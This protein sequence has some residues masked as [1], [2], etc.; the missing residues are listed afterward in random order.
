MPKLTIGMATY[1]DFDGV[2]FTLQ[3]LR[4]YHN[5]DDIEL[6]VVDNEGNGRLKKWIECWGKGVVRYERYTEKVGTSPSRHMVFR[7]ASGDYVICVDSHVL[8]APNSLDRLWEGD[9]LIHGVM[10]Y[11]NN[12]SCVTCM[13]DEWRSNMWGIWDE[14]KK[15]ED[16]PEEPFEIWGHGLG[17]FGCRKEVWLGFNPD[18]RGFGGEEGY[19]HEKFRKHGRKVLCLPWMRWMH[20]F[21]HKVSYPLNMNDRIRNYLYEFDEIGL[22]PQPIYDHFGINVVKGA[23]AA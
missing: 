14:P 8:L 15:I 20:R 19:I 10:L 11:D 9:D 4:L 18:S 5:I 12:R 13:K 3:A 6:L 21:N 1:G 23:M 2:Y 22:D 17:L 16:L 7:Y